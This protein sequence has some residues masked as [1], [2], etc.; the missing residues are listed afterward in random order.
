MTNK[1]LENL[2]TAMAASK[3]E[4]DKISQ[5][6][7][8]NQASIASLLDKMKKSKA[9]EMEDDEEKE[10]PEIEDILKMFYGSMDYMNRRM[11]NIAN[12]YY[13]ISDS[14]YS[15]AKVGH[16]PPLTPSAMGKMLKTCGMDGDFEVGKKYVGCASTNGRV[17][18]LNV[19]L[20]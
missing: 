12:M 17:A 1:E 5:E 2:K 11:D 14:M 19:D 9:G 16:L 8:T 3:T 20:T 7:A 13:G 4:L 15:H 6:F 18:T 10:G